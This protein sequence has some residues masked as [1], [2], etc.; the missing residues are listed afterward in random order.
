MR[1]IN[2][3]LKE[4]VENVEGC[5]TVIDFKIKARKEHSTRTIEGPCLEDGE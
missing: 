5:D 1:D 2:D 3:L 4:I